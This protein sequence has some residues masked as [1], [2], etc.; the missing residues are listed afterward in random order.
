MTSGWNI[1]DA[2]ETIADRLPD[3]PALWHGDRAVS[4]RQL[5]ERAD[6]VAAGLLAIGG[7]QQDKV[8]QYLYN[9]PEYVES[10]F[11]A[12]KAGL[13][14]VN[15]NYRYTADELAYLWDNADVTAVI[16]HGS[17]AERCHQVAHLVP[18][19]RT[20]LWVDDGSGSCPSWATPYE[21][22]ANQGVAAGRT[23]GPWGRSPDDLLL[24]YTGGTTGMPK[25]VMWRQDDL[26]H[27]L[28]SAAK[29]KLPE[30]DQDLA[31]LAA[32][33]VA[34]GPR[35]LAAA[36]LMHGT[37]QF[38]AM[39]A[40]FAG[41]SIATMPGRR[42]DAVELLDTVARL[43]IKSFAMVGD[44]MGKPILGA[45]D[46]E[47]DR[48]DVS[49]MR[50]ITTSGVMCSAETKAGLLRHMPRLIIADTL[51]SSE[52]IGM[53]TSTATAATLGTAGTATARFT[54]GPRTSAI[55]EDGR[56]VQPGSGELGRLAL[57]GNVPIGYYK[58]EAKSAATFVVVDGVR[59]SVP[60]DWVTV[61]AD[62]TLTLLGRGSQCINTGGEK[63]YPEEVE[64]ALKLHPS[65][66]DAAVVGVPDDRFG[67]AVTAIIEPVPGASVDEAEL[68][69][70]VR[71]TLAAFKSPKR[72]LPIGAMGRA[73]N[74]KLDYKGL[75]TFA[76]EALGID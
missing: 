10:L 58:D 45:L 65:V 42:F 11:A 6:G 38:A 48:W 15:T 72:V 1:A 26:V 37:G 75:G 29:V 49:S 52:A 3:A 41:G 46:A 21:D 12:F 16:F 30:G 20:W 76:R 33:I 62:G 69:A 4:W 28:D 47:P 32:R 7:C 68:I 35:H 22:A 50:V 19:V 39:T 63:V 25:G 23:R 74:G 8:A 56:I 17:F 27:A 55:T 40:L 73:A 57:R 43:Q 61:E 71:S 13:V 14:P 60:G 5:D 24:M 9:A 67:Q 51:G 2:W 54:L 70:H 34:P 66:A 31:V 64:E 59:W 44:A 36:P 18:K 53:A